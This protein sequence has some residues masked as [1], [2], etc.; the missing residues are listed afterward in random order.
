MCTIMT[1]DRLTFD[2]NR[3]LIEDQIDSD[4]R[5]NPDGF[6]LILM[7]DYDTDHVVL[8]A[9]DIDPLTTLLRTCDWRRMWL[10][11]RL[12][13]GTGVDIHGTHAFRARG[14]WLVMHN[15][16]LT[17]ESGTREHVDSEAIVK[18]IE[19]IGAE[20]TVTWL[21]F[22][23]PYANVFLVNLNS[24]KWYMTR[25][26]SGMLYTDSRF[27]YSTNE[28]QPLLT[29]PVKSHTWEEHDEDITSL[30]DT[31]Y[32]QPYSGDATGFVTPESV[33]TCDSAYT[34][35]DWDD[36]TAA[37]IELLKSATSRQRKNK[38]RKKA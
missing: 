32:F 3:T 36:A 13:T 33:D 6:S 15:G 31:K 22:F 37:D 38:G 19:A 12:A 23:E 18:S 24:G 9:M 5:C 7:G 25:S 14:G 34:T 17:A 26:Q 16:I 4:A 11:C 27:N 8:H 2:A 1:F 29:L 10:H 28:I 21:Q 35:L 20:G 30:M